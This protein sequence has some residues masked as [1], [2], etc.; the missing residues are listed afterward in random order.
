MKL[1]LV[2]WKFQF[3]RILVDTPI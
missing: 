2:S 1:K 3:H